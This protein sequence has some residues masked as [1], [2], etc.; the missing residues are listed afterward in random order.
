MSD[1]DSD[2]DSDDDEVLCTTEEQGDGNDESEEEE[3]SGDPSN[4]GLEDDAEN[5]VTMT[6]SGRTVW[7]WRCSKYR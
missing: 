1:S 2:S 3:D 6:R 4:S 5:L 7:S